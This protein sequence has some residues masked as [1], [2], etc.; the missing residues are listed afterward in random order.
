MKTYKAAPLVIIVLVAVTSAHTAQSQTRIYRSYRTTRRS[1]EYE[2]QNSGSFPKRVF[3]FRKMKTIKS[4]NEQ[5]AEE[6][7]KNYYY[8]GLAFGYRAAPY[9][10]NGAPQLNFGYTYSNP[11]T[12]LTYSRSIDGKQFGS[13]YLNFGMSVELGKIN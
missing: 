11:A 5:E 3:H 1:H 4:K 7:Q 10:L 8:A 13:Y 12:N 2:E 6:I 9:V